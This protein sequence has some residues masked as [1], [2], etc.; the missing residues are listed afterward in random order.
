MDKEDI[1]TNPFTQPLCE[2]FS[3]RLDNLCNDLSACLE[4]VCEHLIWFVLPRYESTNMRWVIE[5]NFVLIF[6]IVAVL[7]VCVW[8]MNKYRS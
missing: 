3:V 4:A 6:A 5:V 2:G 7:T 1:D 8:L